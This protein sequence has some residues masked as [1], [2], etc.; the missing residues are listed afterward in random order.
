MALAAIEG[1]TVT[2]P[3]D[4]SETNSNTDRPTGLTDPERALL[5]DRVDTC[6]RDMAPA[7]TRDRDRKIFWLY[8]REGLT[9][10]EIAGLPQI[11]LT[12]KGVESTLYRLIQLVRTHLTGARA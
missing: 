3:L 1:N 11:S 10:K 5:V 4:G 9:A 12:L 8:Y 6:L 2:A 7:E